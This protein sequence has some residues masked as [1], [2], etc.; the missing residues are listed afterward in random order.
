VVGGNRKPGDKRVGVVEE[1]LKNFVTGCRQKV[2]GLGGRVV[3]IASY[4]GSY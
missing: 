1:L 4:W 3:G 2:K